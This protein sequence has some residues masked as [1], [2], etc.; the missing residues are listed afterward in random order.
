M[1]SKKFILGIFGDE[2]I[3]LEAVPAIQDKGVKI[4]DVF[5]PFPIHGLDVAMGLR[6]SKLHTAGFIFGI[7]GTSIAFGFMTWANTFNWR[8]NFAGKPFWYVPGYIPITFELTVLMASAGMVATFLYL[9]RLAPGVEK[10]I[11]DPRQTDDK[12]VV[13]VEIDE[14]SDVAAITAALKTAGAEEV[15]EKVID[16]WYRY[17]IM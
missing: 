12:M 16:N 14:H 7:T 9:C 10:H 1:A 2:D 3:L 6:E 4:H 15:N 8:T 11:M 17:K 13:A 5:T